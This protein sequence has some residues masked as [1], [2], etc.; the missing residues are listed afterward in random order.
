MNQLQPGSIEQ[1]TAEIRILKH[2]TAINIIEIG[3]RL[4]KAKELVPHGEWGRWLEEQVDFTDR[5][6]QRFMRAAREFSNTTAM[7]GL[8]PTK[9][10]ALLDVSIE[11]RERFIQEPQQLPTGE[12]KTVN[13]MTTRELQEAIKARKVAEKAAKEAEARAKEAEHKLL[14]A[15]NQEPTIIEKTIEVIPSDIE[16][17]LLNARVAITDHTRLSDE[18]KR[19]KLELEATRASTFN[20]TL[21]MEAKVSTFTGRIKIFLREMAPLGYLGHEVMGTSPQAQKEYERAIAA[22]ERWC[23]DM[24]DAM[25][26]PREEKTI[27][28]EV[29]K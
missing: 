17:E 3:S 6:A 18:N 7:S 14:E 12:T 10:F 20:D 22:L 27:D 23:G 8:S 25:V 24:R 16:R 4:I 15:Q 29:M 2:Q 26:R 13:E 1:L 5:S 9:V 11:E 28:V 19:L 21:T